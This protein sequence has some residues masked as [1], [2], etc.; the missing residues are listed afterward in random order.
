MSLPVGLGGVMTGR[1]IVSGPAG[2]D[3]VS[4]LAMRGLSSV[5]VRWRGT[6]R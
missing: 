2:M 6:S 1:A 5:D 4:R 3:L